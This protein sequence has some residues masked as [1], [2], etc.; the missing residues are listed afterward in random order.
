MSTFFRA[1]LWLAAG[2]LSCALHAAS[3]ETYVLGWGMNISGEATGI[4]AVVPPNA[5]P[6]S[7]GVV[8]VAGQ[9]LRN[10][11]GVSAGTF[12][13]LAVRGDGTVCGWGNN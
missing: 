8:A 6:R 2:V 7:T 4:P 13:S 1:S 5:Q 12:F 10:P 3:P 9:I 11:A